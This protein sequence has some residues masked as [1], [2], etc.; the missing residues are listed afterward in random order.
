ME[1]LNSYHIGIKAWFPDSTEG[2][3]MGHLISKNVTDLDYSFLFTIPERDN[4]Q[5]VVK[6]TIENLIS[7][8][9]TLPPLVNPPFLLVNNDDLANLSYL[10]EPSVLHSI[11]DRY[12]KE[13]IYTYSGIVLIAMNPFTKLDI[14]NPATMRIYSGKARD[15][16]DPHLFAI[17]EQ[18]YRAMIRD[19]KNQSIVVSGESGA[20]KTISATFIMRYFAV[21]DDLHRDASITVNKASAVEDAVLSTNPIL[22]SF[23]NSKTTR[24]DNSSRFGKYIELMFSKPNSDTQS[25]K[26]VGAKLRTYLLERSRLVFQPESERNYHI[27][28]QLCSALP[29]AERK[30]WGLETWDKYE[31]LKQGKTGVSP[32][33]D[34]VIE[35]ANTQK[36]LS[37]VG[38]SL[39]SQLDI[40]KVCVALLHMGN[41]KITGEKDES[42]IDEND[43]GLTMSS[44]LLGLNK[45]EFKKWMTNKNLVINRESTDKKIGLQSALVARDSVAKFIYSMLF[46]HLV[47]VINSNLCKDE[48]NVG[49]FIGVLDIYGFEHFQKNS[50]EQFC[51]NY[52]NEKL[53]QEF[54]RHVFRL[55]QEEYV[56]EKI[57]WSFID[58][59]DNQA[60]IDMIERKVGIIDLLNEES[61]LATGT[62]EQ[63]AQKLYNKFSDT[64][65]HK[66]FLKPR[67]G[68]SQFTIKHY[69]CE[70]TYD[71][72][73]FIE[74]N[75]DTVS[76]KQMEV[77]VQSDFD[78]LREIIKIPEEI[79]GNASTNT[80]TITKAVGT[81]GRNATGSR[82]KKPT[83][84]TIFKNSL[85]ELMKT[86]RL[87][88][89]HYIRCI[90][91][92]QAKKRF[93]FEPQM[94][95]QQLR[96]C[97]VLET[98]KISCAGYPTKMPYDY[99]ANRYYMLTK[100]NEWDLN[101]SKNWSSI[102]VK[103]NILS[104]DKY[105][106]GLTKIFFRAGQLAYLE[107]L[108][109][110]KLRC[111][112]DLFQKNVKRYRERKKYLEI[113]SS[114]L[115][116]QRVFRGWVARKFVQTLRR[117]VAATKI[118]KVVRGYLARKD[119]KKKRDAVIKIQ[120]GIKMFLA[121]RRYKNRVR[122]IAAKK[123][124]LC[125]R[126]KIL[127][128]WLKSRIKKIVT[129]QNLWRKKK[130][131]RELIELRKAARDVGKV[132][133]KYF[134]LENKLIELS[135][136]V[137]TRDEEKLIL[138]EKIEKLEKLAEKWKGIA[139]N[140]E[141]R[142]KS[143]N[144]YLDEAKSS[145]KAT[146]K[147]VELER[148]ASEK[149]KNSLNYSLKKKDE[150]IENLTAELKLVKDWNRNLKERVLN[151]SNV[152]GSEE[153]MMLRKEV[154]YYKSQLSEQS[155]ESLRLRSNSV[156]RSR[157]RN[158]TPTNMSPT[159]DKS[160]VEESKGTKLSTPPSSFTRKTTKVK[161][162][163]SKLSHDT[164]FKT[165]PLQNGTA[166][167]EQLNSEKLLHVLKSTELKLELSQNLILDLTLPN[168]ESN[169]S[170]KE[171]FFP[172]HIL[173]QVLEKLF[174]NKL[175]PTAQDLMEGLMHSVDFIT[176]FIEEK[177]QLRYNRG[178]SESPTTQSS[179]YGSE[180]LDCLRTIRN[181]FEN[182]VNKIFNG[183]TSK[184]YKAFVILVE[185]CIIEC[186]S[187]PEY[188]SNGKS[189]FWSNWG[190]KTKRDFKELIDHF[191]EL[192]RMMDGYY[193]DQ[194]LKN[195]ILT[196]LLTLIGSEGFNILLTKKN[197]FSFRR[198]YQILYNVTRL[199]EFL[200]A[201]ELNSNLKQFVMLQ[202]ASKLLSLL[203]GIDEDGAE[204]VFDLCPNLNK[205]QVMKLLSNYAPEEFDNQE[206]FFEFFK[207]VE[208]LDF[209]DDNDTALLLS[210]ELSEFTLPDVEAVEQV[211]AFIP[212][213][214]DVPNIGLA[215]GFRI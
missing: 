99:F 214:M 93:L 77:L 50:F 81:L 35:Y 61:N 95:L 118:Q 188:V 80:S 23:G 43:P 143:V 120:S 111:I 177:E 59:S 147:D 5:I 134:A 130:A 38:I 129:I 44:K 69:A 170:M 121:V 144:E 66:F 25:T 181:N 17:A 140:L 169:L 187:L 192:N 142:S 9:F 36:A 213:W 54:N 208:Y 68:T 131:R 141:S 183:W 65:I 133:E 90:K 45:F 149:E 136:A 105:Q 12:E 19:G 152:N 53:Q 139:K 157:S 24:N 162:K 39:T 114:V 29:L 205:T 49:S 108:R 7:D 185:P 194:Y 6:S 70:V 207:A 148:R 156:L 56:A 211:Y 91:P 47:N 46:D 72:E 13:F 190:G 74:K 103:K 30:E 155:S 96:A 212:S 154:A 89:C 165:A 34:D 78:F 58:F 122:E 117:N 4:T 51:I 100:S 101:D 186:E 27:F 124:Q 197:F 174:Q 98:I 199:K 198:G 113:K 79:P 128:L 153:I 75:K 123:I 126:R 178:L 87:T 109:T 132:K 107:K 40:F 112:F 85:I 86:M 11:K 200:A 18:A 167:Y 159:P 14:Y 146:F 52:A 189:S 176:Q 204:M 171:I 110:E 8:K 195:D 206:R 67:F 28:Y 55:E 182:L 1:Q 116:I 76:D 26:I 15:E 92:N 158:R 21:V 164:K 82:G 172:S 60:C 151:A 83:L 97:G 84:G 180:S 106:I 160:F 41:I 16:S 94:V 215:L 201:I 3:I 102:I 166:S 191:K 175:Y 203:D 88:E 137:K 63:F 104:E 115:T 57:K 62:D 32:G 168:F 64:N 31:Y 125:F 37:T 150:E 20:G 196:L 179:L 138:L 163:G 209:N 10:H 22:E 184:L 202:E 161:R 210:C 48:E 173:G 119:Y 145:T 71:V 193:L 135:Q 42:N 33:M 2:W 127:R 73:R